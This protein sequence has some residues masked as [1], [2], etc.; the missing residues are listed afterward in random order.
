MITYV[1]WRKG[2][3]RS[4]ILCSVTIVTRS[5]LIRNSYSGLSVRYGS[6]STRPEG[7]KRPRASTVFEAISHTKH[8]ITIIYS[9]TMAP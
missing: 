4:K 7:A 1:P 2:P 3:I 5:K 8:T 9:V 6:N